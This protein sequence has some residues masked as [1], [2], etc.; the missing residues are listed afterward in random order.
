MIT[1]LDGDVGRIMDLLQELGLDEHTIVFFTSDNGPMPDREMTAYFDS[2]GPFRGGKRDLYEGGIRVP[3]IV[4]WKGMILPGST[5]G[6][7][8]AFWDFLPT[9]C[10]LARV[11]PPGGIDGISYMPVL[12]GNPQPEHDVLY[13]EFGERG[14]SQALRAGPWKLVRNQVIAHPP[15][16]LELYD[17]EADPGEAHN[18]AGSNPGKTNDMVIKMEQE[19]IESEAFPLLQ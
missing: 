18:L 8:S 7:V 11:S 9:A 13:W 15:G 14:G 17:L 10:E 4:S 5:T 1:R 6:H 2:N 12:L 3:L 19:R 16:T